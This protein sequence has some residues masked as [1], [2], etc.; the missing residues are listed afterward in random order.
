MRHVKLMVLRAARAAGLFAIAR[1]A[2]A[3]AVRILCYHGTWRADT[4]GFRGDAMFMH[5]HT[6]A[7]RLATL[8]RLGYP[9]VSLDRAVAGL[10]G[11]I[12]LPPN[13]V[14]ITIDDGWYGTYA[15][16]LPALQ[17][18]GMPAT[19]YC[20]TQQ[21]QDGGT[22]P[23]VMARWLARF[24]TETSPQQQAYATATDRG[25]SL[26]VRRDAC[27]VYCA[28]AG[29]D[30]TPFIATRNFAYMTAAELRDAASLGLD[31]QLHTHRHDLRDLSA[32]VITREITDNRAALG[33]ILAANDR[34]RASA[35]QGLH[36]CYPSG[37]A[38]ADAAETLRGLGLASA[39]TTQQGLAWPGDSLFLLRRLMDGEQISAIG[40]E[41]EISGFADVLRAVRGLLTLRT[42]RR[43]VAGLAGTIRRKQAPLHA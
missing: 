28:A 22:V 41:A 33:V 6:F 15:D 27:D 8:R 21:L 18:A 11:D 9:V 34:P 13:A 17:A 25:L 30:T 2:T 26:N 24:A 19:L 3:P 16:M 20:D 4:A 14:A 10:R 31:V 1:R 35:A 39:T 38:S 40:F 37:V 5:P 12:P 36:F 32:A 7:A 23:H 43:A 29:I 42:L